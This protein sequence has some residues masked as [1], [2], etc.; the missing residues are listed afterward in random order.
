MARHPV[1][2][3]RSPPAA[4]R[5][6][7][8]GLAPLAPLV[9][10]ALVDSPGPVLLVQMRLTLAQQRQRQE[11]ARRVAKQPRRRTMGARGALMARAPAARRINERAAR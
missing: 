4:E 5:T 8:L 11:A 6:A 2:P 10:Q 7:A 1:A 3:R 9:M